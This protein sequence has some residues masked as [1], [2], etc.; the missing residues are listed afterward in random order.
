M[1]CN[2]ENEWHVCYS[3]WEFDTEASVCVILRLEPVTWDILLG[4]FPV[5]V[6]TLQ[7]LTCWNFSCGCKYLALLQIRFLDM[8]ME[9]K[10]HLG[11]IVAGIGEKFDLI[12]FTQNP[13]EILCSMDT[14]L[15]V[16]KQSVVTISMTSS[17]RFILQ[18]TSYF[19]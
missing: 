16:F 7:V 10:K 14:I 2:S 5:S 18:L 8:S 9:T 19:L 3:T 13:I 15:F 1:Q 6:P 4:A 12:W 11:Y 17:F